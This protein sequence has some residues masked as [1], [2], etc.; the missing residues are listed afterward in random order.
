[1]TR[2]ILGILLAAAFL[3]LG[4]GLLVTALVRQ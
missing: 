4:F 3:I 1:M 2:R